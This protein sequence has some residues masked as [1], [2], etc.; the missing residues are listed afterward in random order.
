MNFQQLEYVL[1]VHQYKH[2]GEAAERCNITQATLSAMI[3]KLED[4]LGIIIF[5][6]S[7]HPIKTTEVGI[8][9]IQIAKKTLAC[10]QDMQALKTEE[11]ETLKGHLRI[12]IIPTIANTFLPIVL[13]ALMEKNPDVL[14]TI[15]EITTAE[16]IQQLRK[17]NIDIGILA[18]P[19]E[20]SDMDETILYYE[21]MMIYGVK[22]I[23]TKFISSKDLQNRKIWL[24]E[25]G[26]CFR[27]QS[28]TICD[29]KEKHIETSHLHFEGNSFDTLLNITDLFGGYTL[30]PELFYNKLSEDKKQTT[31]FFEKPIPVR[32]VSIISYRPLVKQ[33]T[34]KVL[35][36]FIQELIEPH[37]S[38]CKYQKKDLEII[39]IHRN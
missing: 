3:R 11:S 6:R 28:L 17:D 37:L 38:T 4:E 12:G 21:P 15:Q 13:P 26:N 25:A 9:F 35:A 39:G 10:R 30:I 34:I 1:A 22:D 18:T 19:V 33:N 32:E 36:K 8:D 20:E 23:D 27:E 29:I 24:L 5:D 7:R 2:F 14:L 31:K 16:I